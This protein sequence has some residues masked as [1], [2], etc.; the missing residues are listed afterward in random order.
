MSP[1]ALTTMTVT[2]QEREHIAVYEV[3]PRPA[4]F[5]LWERRR[6]RQLHWFVECIAEAV[7]TKTM[8]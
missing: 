8:S 7:R 2:E 4:V 3:V 1:A 6:N 5:S